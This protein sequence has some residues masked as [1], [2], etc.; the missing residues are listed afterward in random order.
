MTSTFQQSGYALE[1]TTAR[2]MSAVFAE[3]ELLRQRCQWIFLGATLAGALLILL[4][5]WLLTRPIKRLERSSRA[6]AGGRLQCPASG[7]LPDEIGDL[8]RSYN[9][10]ADTIEDK[11]NALEL[12]VR[13]REDLWPI[14]PTS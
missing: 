14:S 12:A 3:A 9:Q 4:F 6:F 1:L 13:Q 7:E 8:T 5:S 11:I 10:M 2:S